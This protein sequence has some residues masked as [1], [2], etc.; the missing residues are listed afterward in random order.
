ML[1]ARRASPSASAGQSRSDAH[2]DWKTAYR[3]ERS[4]DQEAELYNPCGPVKELLERR[5]SAR[6][7]QWRHTCFSPKTDSVV[8]GNPGKQLSV[9]CI[10][11]P[12][13]VLTLQN[14]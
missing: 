12:K 10:I 11:V 7:Q 9:Y 14:Y 1:L 3:W 6:Q 13:M 5:H 2:N 4:H 8:V